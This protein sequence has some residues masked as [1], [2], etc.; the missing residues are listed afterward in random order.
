MQAI[1]IKYT[2]GF[3]AGDT[4]GLSEQNLF[5]SNFPGAAFTHGKRRGACPYQ[6]LGL[7]LPTD[8]WWALLQMD[9]E[10]LAQKLSTQ[11]VMR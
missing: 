8:E 11:E 5:D 10:V 3:L 2:R 9:P 7:R 4:V 1:D 6:L